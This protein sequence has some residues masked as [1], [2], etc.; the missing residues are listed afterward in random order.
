MI[1]IKDKSLCC[2]CGLCETVC[3]KKAIAM[4]EDEKGFLYPHIDETQCIKCNI[5]SYRCVFQKEHNRNTTIKSVYAL[6]HKND[7]ILKK[8]SSGG[9]FTA[10]SDIVLKNG[11]CIYGADYDENFN[12]IIKKAEN[13][14]ERNRLRESKYVHS[15]AGSAY[16]QVKEDLKN[17]KEVL[18]TGLPCQCAS[19]LGFLKEKPENLFIIDLLCHGAPSNKLLKDHI[20]YWEKRKNSKISEYHYR[21]KKYG[22]DHNHIIKFS[23][24]A[25][26]SSIDIKRILKLFSFT[27]R[28]SCYNC[29]YASPKRYGDITIGD[30]WESVKKAGI[31]N[32]KGTSAVIINTEKGSKLLEK[33]KE[34]CIIKSININTEKIQALDHPLKRSDTVNKLWK[35]YHK[36]GYKFI[37]DKYGKLTFKS[38]FYQLLLRFL[39]ITKNNFLFN[40]IKK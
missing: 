9:A 36:Y 3:P 26:N 25:E 14:K 24:G 7:N 6:Q 27:A 12:V 33:A 2:G 23:D 15:F 29:P 22:Y 11:G 19:L 39:Y 40:K 32:N 4:K 28:E 21:S 38:L 5:C 20:K 1:N 16:R 17:G 18:F 34:N 30:L 13:E 10:F 31:T 37:L 8:S 35:D